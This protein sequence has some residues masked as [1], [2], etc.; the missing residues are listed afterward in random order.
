MATFEAESELK[1]LMFDALTR[2]HLRREPDARDPALQIHAGYCVSL[3]PFV[4]LGLDALR[5]RDS[6]HER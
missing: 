6:H 2:R 4:T 3:I 1:V 5:R